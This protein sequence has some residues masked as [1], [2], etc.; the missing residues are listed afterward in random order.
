METSLE[1]DIAR[2]KCLSKSLLTLS[3]ENSDRM[4]VVYLDDKDV[5][6]KY[7]KISLADGNIE[8]LLFYF[9]FISFW[10]FGF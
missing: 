7:R 6:L 10:V 2:R 1:E 9:I 5:D 4:T 3:Y 8:L